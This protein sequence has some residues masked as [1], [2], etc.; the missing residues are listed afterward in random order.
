MQ[1]PPYNPSQPPPG[2]PSQPQQQPY[3]NYQPPSFPPPRKPSRFSRF[4]ALIMAHK[5]ISGIVAI[6]LL[7]VIVI[8]SIQNAQQPQANVAPVATS[9][10]VQSQAP[11]A[12]PTQAIAPT[13]APTSAPVSSG[14][15]ATRGTPRLGGPLSDFIGA[16]GQ[17]NSN[18]NPPSYQ[19]QEVNNINEVGAMGI[20]ASCQSPQCEV[21]QHIDD[22]TI[23]SPDQTNGY[24]VSEAE[25]KCMAFAPADA[26]F[27]QK[28]PYGD[29]TGYDMVYTSATLAKEFPASEFVDGNSNQVAAGT[30]DVSYLYADNHQDI[31]SCDMITGEQQT[32]G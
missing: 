14:L 3:G 23:Q 24:T 21:Q 16:Y 29:G 6:A 26:H 7:V 25:A 4:V 19:F 11:T 9:A 31:G 12:A 22:I 13:S 15:P 1:Q 8:A 20:G 32:T 28:I 2:Y 27:K 18:S 30:F 10:P 17:P 5:I